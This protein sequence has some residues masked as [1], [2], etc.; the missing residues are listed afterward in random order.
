MSEQ[1]ADLGLAV[2]R[3]AQA[4]ER[5][6]TVQELD[7]LMTRVSIQQ[8]TV[9]GMVQQL[10][11]HDLRTQKAMQGLEKMGNLT[12]KAH[13]QLMSEVAARLE[14]LDQVGADAD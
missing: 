7:Y 4:Q 2:H 14:W 13:E 8:Q 9:Q 3:L 6:A 10:G 11:E 12:F 5:L 1:P